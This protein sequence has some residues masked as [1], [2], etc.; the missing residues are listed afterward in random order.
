MRQSDHGDLRG[1]FSLTRCG[2][3]SAP[4]QVCSEVQLYEGSWVP[5]PLSSFTSLCSENIIS[6]HEESKTTTKITPSDPYGAILRSR[7]LTISWE[8]PSLIQDA[9]LKGTGCDGLLIFTNSLNRGSLAL[10][11]KENF[12]SLK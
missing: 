8:V 3:I 10:A 9:V 11:C 12:Y 5:S 4:F 1:S 2:C 7:L 6:K